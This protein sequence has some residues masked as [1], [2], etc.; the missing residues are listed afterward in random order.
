[1]REEIAKTIEVVSSH[2]KTALVITGAANFNAWYGTYEPI[3]KFI[4]SFLGIV[5]VCVL[6][7]KH[8]LDIKITLTRNK[9]NDKDK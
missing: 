1:M 8:A 2:P 5:L 4:T 6:I 3:A 9:P 7:I